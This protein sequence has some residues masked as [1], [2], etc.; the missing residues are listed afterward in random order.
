M[1]TV[2]RAMNIRIISETPV[3]TYGGIGYSSFDWRLGDSGT[4]GLGVRS[5]IAS[6]CHVYGATGFLLLASGLL[7]S[8]FWLLVSGLIMMR[9]VRV[10]WLELLFLGL[11][12]VGFT[13]DGMVDVCGLPGFSGFSGFSG[14]PRLPW[15]FWIFWIYPHLFIYVIRY[16]YKCIRNRD[17]DGEGL[18]GGSPAPGLAGWH[19]LTLAGCPSHNGCKETYSH[20]WWYLFMDFGRLEPSRP[21][22]PLKAFQPSSCLSAL[23]PSCPSLSWRTLRADS[24]DAE[25]MRLLPKVP[26]A[27]ERIYASRTNE[28]REQAKVA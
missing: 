9:C 16:P 14:L 20:F 17:F 26:K 8:G 22:K 27:D 6:N 23:L 24:S 7:A 3:M 12:F 2:T 25:P 4:R 13:W 19:S 18:V 28:A 10:N 1:T 5:C 11:R 21:E 15:I